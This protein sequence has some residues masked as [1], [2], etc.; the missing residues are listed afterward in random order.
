[1]SQVPTHSRVTAAGEGSI[2]E[3]LPINA[4]RKGMF[5]QFANPKQ[6]GIFTF[7]G[8]APSITNGILWRQEWGPLPGSGGLP[9]DT[10]NDPAEFFIGQIKVRFH[11]ND[12][13]GGPSSLEL[14]VM[15][16]EYSA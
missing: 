2:E 3:V 4:N 9:G 14:N 12:G 15:S 7:D 5:I 6:W 11:A 8:S 10:K 1:M 13:S 16:I